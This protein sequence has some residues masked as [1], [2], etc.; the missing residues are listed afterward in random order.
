[1]TDELPTLTISASDRI[2]TRPIEQDPESPRYEQDQWE[3]SQ[4][5]PGV[6]IINSWQ[7]YHKMWL[8]LAVTDGGIYNIFLS[9]GGRFTLVHSH[10]SKIY[11]MFYVDDGH[12]LFCAGD[13]WYFTVNTGTVWTEADEGVLGPIPDEGVLGPIPDEG[14]LIPEYDDWTVID[15]WWPEPDLDETVP[16]YDN[17]MWLGALGAAAYS[18]AAKS[19]AVIGLSTGLWALVAYAEDH[20]IYRAVY[21]GGEWDVAYDTTTIWTDKWYPAIAGGP[22]GILAGAGSKLLRSLDAGVNWTILR[23]LGSVIKS[24]VVSNQSTT[25][26]FA[27]TVEPTPGSDIDKIYLSYDLGDSL[28]EDANRAGSISS[29]QSVVPTGTNEVQTMFTVLGKRTADTTKQDYK[30]IEA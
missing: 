14:V 4:P 19:L 23:D 1:M 13:G 16:E 17:W 8:V 9:V 27:I 20:R 26:V 18:P 2:M 3:V 28:A 15:S 25:P 24:I 30:I 11:N 7:I 22:A 5:L 12:C 6:R 21:P 29:V 10:P